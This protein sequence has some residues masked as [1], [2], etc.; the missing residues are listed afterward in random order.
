[1]SS[2]QTLADRR[3]RPALRVLYTHCIPVPKTDENKENNKIKNKQ[4][5]ITRR[6]MLCDIFVS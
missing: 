4:S 1:M 6:E 5:L 2:L 3:G